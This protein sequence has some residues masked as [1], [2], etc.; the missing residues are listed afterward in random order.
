MK[1]PNEYD[2]K[3]KARQME[4]LMHEIEDLQVEIVKNILFA[5]GDDLTLQNPIHLT[6]GEGELNKLFLDEEGELMCELDCDMYPHE[7]EFSTLSANDRLW[8][9]RDLFD[10]LD[11]ESL[12]MSVPA[13]KDSFVITRLRREDLG[14]IGFDADAV[15]DDTMSLLASKMANDYFEQLY[16]PSL[17]TIADIMELPRKEA[18][19]ED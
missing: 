18:S 6:Y 16:W 12:C 3:G 2:F 19:H 9:I 1:N 11:I 13:R 5:M 15:D 7:T 14:V 4:T 8:V 10:R 17:E